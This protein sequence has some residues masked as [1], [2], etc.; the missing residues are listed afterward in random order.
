M[1]RVDGASQHNRYQVLP[2]PDH[3][4]CPPDPYR[5]LERYRGTHCCFNDD[6]QVRVPAGGVYQHLRI[7]VCLGTCEPGVQSV[8]ASTT[9]T[10]RWGRSWADSIVTASTCAKTCGSNV[11]IPVQFVCQTGHRL[12]NAGGA[13]VRATRDRRAAVGAAHPVPGRR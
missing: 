4:V 1:M 5:L 9:T 6:I 8:A 7:S 2:L 13:A 10:S 11:L 12:H 3:C